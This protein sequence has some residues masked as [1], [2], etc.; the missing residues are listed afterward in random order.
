MWVREY[1]ILTK[2][3][4]RLYIP[5]R[6]WDNPHINQQEYIKSLNRLSPVERAQL[7]MGNWDVVMEGDMFKEAWFDIIEASDVPKGGRTVRYWDLAAT[8]PSKENPDPDWT[9]GCKVTMVNGIYYVLDMVAM[10]GT[11]GDVD[12]VLEA[13]AKKDGYEV[14]IWEEQDPGQA[15]KALIH[16]H[17]IGAFLGYAHFPGLT[18]GKDKVVRALPFSSAAQGRRVKLVAAHWNRFFLDIVKAFPQLGI[19]DDVVDAMSGSI[20]TL[21]V[22]LDPSI[23]WDDVPVEDVIGGTMG[24]REDIPSRDD[25]RDSRDDGIGGYFD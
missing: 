8:P 15:G 16:Q 24:E 14:E 1:F 25:F 17:S 20:N 12:T 10:R 9:I 22:G 19:H 2:N 3:K 13:T 21:S 5:S 4:D 6:L 11:P 7:L 18:K 23:N